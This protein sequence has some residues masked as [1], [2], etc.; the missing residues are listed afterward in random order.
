[1]PAEFRRGRAFCAPAPITGRGLAEPSSSAASGHA[2]R[3]S[4]SPCKYCRTQQSA[5][6]MRSPAALSAFIPV[7]SGRQDVE[8]ASHRRRRRDAARLPATSSAVADAYEISAT[9]GAS[10]ALLLILFRRDCHLFRLAFAIFPRILWSPRLLSRFRI[11]ATGAMSMVMAF[12]LPS[13][14]C[15]RRSP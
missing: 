3:A 12:S 2:C 7:T 15:F 14:E 13:R 5:V 11:N 8:Y 4:P 6:F 1:M 10:E 9:I